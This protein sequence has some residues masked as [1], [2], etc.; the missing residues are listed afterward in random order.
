MKLYLLGIVKLGQLTSCG[1][2]VKHGIIL[3][4]VMLNEGRHDYG[5]IITVP[6]VI[7]P[8]ILIIMMVMVKKLN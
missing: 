1:T 7:R 6:L 2:V 8:I 5:L 3:K 4:N